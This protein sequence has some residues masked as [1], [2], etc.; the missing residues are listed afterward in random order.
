MILHGDHTIH[1]E[2]DRTRRS[3]SPH[4]IVHDISPLLQP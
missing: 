3:R 4:R 2:L 1:R